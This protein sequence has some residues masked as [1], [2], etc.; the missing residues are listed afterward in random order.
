MFHSEIANHNQ[1][2]M[3]RIS[4]LQG[5]L[6]GY[7]SEKDRIPGQP[8]I[9]NIGMP[10]TNRSAA[11]AEESA[12]RDQ[13]GDP[14]FFNNFFELRE[15]VLALIKTAVSVRSPLGEKK[16]PCYL[17]KATGQYSDTAVLSSAQVFPPN[18]SGVYEKFSPKFKTHSFLMAFLKNKN[19][20][21]SGLS[22][23]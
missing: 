8:G 2:N 17:I 4:P 11:I 6:C 7:N 1:C 15:Q 22:F 16:Y 10:K 13:S 14:C 20:F 18:S 12:D 9:C 5:Y 21:L 3:S 23:Q 19:S